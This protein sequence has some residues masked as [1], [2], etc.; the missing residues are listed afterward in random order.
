MTAWLVLKQNQKVIYTTLKVW[1]PVLFPLLL[2][3]LF[4]YPQK[5][6][7]VFWPRCLSMFVNKINSRLVPHTI[8]QSQVGLCS[9]RLG[10]VEGWKQK[11]GSWLITWLM[12]WDPG[13]DDTSCWRNVLLALSLPFWLKKQ[14]NNKEMLLLKN[15]QQ[16]DTVNPSALCT[17]YGA[18]VC[19]RRATRAAISSQIYACKTATTHTGDG[20]RH[21]TTTI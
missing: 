21:G 11:A 10:M 8:T 15:Y 2:P 5:N 4:I 16:W 13:C 12:R 18:P 20:E 9:S 19:E 3:G 7:T 14:K 17:A 1:L 6:K